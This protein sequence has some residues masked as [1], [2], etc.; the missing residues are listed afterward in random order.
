MQSW[1]ERTSPDGERAVYL[2]GHVG[3]QASGPADLS[4]LTRP[5]GRRLVSQMQRHVLGVLDG[6]LPVAGVPV[7]T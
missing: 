5:G 3:L 6:P 4:A 2:D 7:L 1:K